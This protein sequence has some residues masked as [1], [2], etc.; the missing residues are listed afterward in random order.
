M[1]MRIIRSIK[2]IIFNYDGEKNTEMI[3][4]II[5]MFWFVACFC[6][7]LTSISNNETAMII[8]IEQVITV[9]NFP[10]IDVDAV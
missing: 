4:L 5:I 3:H 2:L 1:L 9:Q 7:D 10:L 8:K 6:K